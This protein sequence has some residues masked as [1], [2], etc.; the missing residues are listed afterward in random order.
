MARLAVERLDVRGDARG[1]VVE[2]ADEA[3]LAAQRNVH[4][5]LTRPGAVRG[6]HRHRR[7]TEILVV[8]GPAMVRIRDGEAEFDTVIA[9]D[10]AYRFVVPPGVAHAVQNTGTEAMVL[11][12]F[13]T[14]PHD[15]DAPDV[16][17]VV[18]IEG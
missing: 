15:P 1:W 6:N 17:R 16:E 14:E 13:N 9:P 18:L 7:G 10:E 2:P 11:I 3:Q 5:V 4:V 12:A 8:H